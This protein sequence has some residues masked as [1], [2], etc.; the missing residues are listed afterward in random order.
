MWNFISKDTVLGGLPALNSSDITGED[1]DVA[2]I[3][4]SCVLE[5]IYIAVHRA[6]SQFTSPIDHLARHTSA[7]KQA[8]RGLRHNQ[9]SV[10]PK[11]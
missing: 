1:T 7:T 10:S 6:I 2:R 3:T 8:P 9:H 4:M 11:G 5:L